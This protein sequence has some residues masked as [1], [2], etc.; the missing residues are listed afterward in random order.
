MRKL[1]EQLRQLLPKDDCDQETLHASGGVDKYYDRMS[2]STTSGEVRVKHERLW[3][4]GVGAEN[5]WMSLMSENPTV[6]GEMA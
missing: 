6:S 2:V 3:R 5:A 4:R 1:Q